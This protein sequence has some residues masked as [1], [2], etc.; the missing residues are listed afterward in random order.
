MQ[1]SNALR[2]EQVQRLVRLLGEAGEVLPTARPQHLIAGLR[3]ILHAA[4]G[5]CVT[6]VTVTGVK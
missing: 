6:D 4:V 3:S 5:G 1:L 2:V